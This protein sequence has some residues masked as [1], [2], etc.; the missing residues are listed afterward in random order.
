MRILFS[1]LLLTTPLFCFCQSLKEIKISISIEN[2]SL[3]EALIKIGEKA[4][5]NLS[6]DSKLIEFDKI[7]SYQASNESVELILDD[8]IND[9]SID[10]LF[11]NRQVILK[12]ASPEQKKIR[13]EKQKLKEIKKKEKSNKAQAKLN[14][15]EISKKFAEQHIKDSLPDP[16]KTSEKDT[17][18]SLSSQNPDSA[19]IQDSTKTKKWSVDIG[20]A[21]LL[22][23]N[24]YHG[25]EGFE[26]TATLIEQSEKTTLSHSVNLKL[27]YEA[28]KI[29]I[30]S[31]AFYSIE[32]RS[33][34]YDVTFETTDTVKSYE[35]TDNSHY[36]EPFIASSGYY[37]LHGTDTT[38]F[39]NYDST[40]IESKDT[41][42][43]TEYQKRDSNITNN[44][45]IKIQRIMIPLLVSYQFGKDRWTI[46]PKLGIIA[47][48]T[49]K[50]KGRS[51][52]TEG[53]AFVDIK[54]LP[55]SNLL[56]L[57][58][59]GVNLSFALNKSF[60]IS[61]EAYYNRNINKVY[62]S[63]YPLSSTVHAY[64]SSIGLRYKF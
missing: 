50:S 1:F 13:E 38:W 30:E 21:P 34:N 40:W 3:E 42:V 24:T 55:Y 44:D 43:V 7:V 15:E 29:G 20:Y 5:V 22:L 64:S 49:L 61:L 39:T 62:Q 46:S 57:S 8:I 60:H 19:S 33:V 12:K 59:S 9:P 28:G 16:R 52:N 10:Y 2:L 47:A 56:L 37:I 36:S 14:E 45:Q 51:L 18:D 32:N 4:D 31:G 54:D 11:L 58:Y 17:E 27:A 48:F 35:F 6:Y 53:N 25:N 23:Y 63:N 41:T 26:G